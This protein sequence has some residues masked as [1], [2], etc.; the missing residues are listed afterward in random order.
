VKAS[1]YLYRALKPTERAKLCLKAQNVQAVPVLRT[2]YV[3]NAKSL[4][5]SYLNT[6]NLT[7]IVLTS[8]RAAHFWVQALASLGLTKLPPVVALGK[9]TAKP[10][11]VAGLPVLLAETN[12]GLGLGHWL[13]K[14]VHEGVFGP[15]TQ[16][17]HLCGQ[18]RRPELGEALAA[19]QLVYHP[20]VVYQIMPRRIVK[21]LDLNP[22][23]A[24]QIAL[25]PSGLVALRTN[26]LHRGQNHATWVA[27]GSTT[28]GA[29]QNKGWGRRSAITSRCSVAGAWRVQGG[30]WQPAKAR[31]ADTL[32]LARKLAHQLRG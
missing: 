12:T 3:P 10:L 23:S 7:V 14:A 16:F 24:V 6:E 8:A 30:V 1:I 4:L 5:A 15:E 28:A 20:L 32:L 26:G 18:L 13:A 29:L 25:S 17:V 11:L 9:A 22:K 19:A 27:I 21:V 2:Q 31:L